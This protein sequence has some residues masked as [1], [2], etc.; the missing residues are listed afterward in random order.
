MWN[1]IFA[2]IGLV[3]SLKYGLILANPKDFYN[4]IHRAQHFIKFNR[5]DEIEN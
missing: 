4:E 2:G 1:Y 5:N 3:P